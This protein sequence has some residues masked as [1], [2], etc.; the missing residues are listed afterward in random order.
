MIQNPFLKKSIN[1][2]ESYTSE[3]GGDDLQSLLHRF[4]NPDDSR[5]H[6]PSIGNLDELEQLAMDVLEEI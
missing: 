6:H 1:L 3:K 4:E 5:D 2:R